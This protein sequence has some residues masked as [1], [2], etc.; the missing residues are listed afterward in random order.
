M[1]SKM[2]R[3]HIIHCQSKLSFILFVLTV[4]GCVIGFSLHEFDVLSNRKNV[5]IVEF[6]V[7]DNG[8]NSSA[9]IRNI[10]GNIFDGDLL[11]TRATQSHP[12]PQPVLVFNSI[13][14]GL[15]E[16]GVLGYAYGA[17]CDEI[18]V[19]WVVFECYFNAS[20]YS[21][22]TGNALQN[23]APGMWIFVFLK[24]FWL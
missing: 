19:D 12:T 11:W 4:I 20:F 14:N 24:K 10:A 8:L 23:A 1:V 2:S 7:L 3:P 6:N 5:L 22:G 15:C 18:G 17:I 16:F 13:N 9:S 21:N